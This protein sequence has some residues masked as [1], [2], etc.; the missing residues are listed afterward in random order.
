MKKH[1]A[2]LRFESD[3]TKV[4]TVDKKGNVKG[5][6][7]GKATVYVYSQNGIYKKLKVTVK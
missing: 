4:A 5:I 1:I 7:K 3:N 2:V 6:A